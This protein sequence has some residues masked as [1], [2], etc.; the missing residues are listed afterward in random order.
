MG[1]SCEG[2]C[3]AQERLG[4]GDRRQRSWAAIVPSIRSSV[5]VSRVRRLD[6]TLR[7]LCIG[8]VGSLLFQGF[9]IERPGSIKTRNT[10][11]AESERASR[12]NRRL[13]F[14]RGATEQRVF[15]EQLAVFKPEDS[16][17]Q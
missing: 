8:I 9:P 10:I 15:A 7:F 16:K 2:D 17:S 1:R 4:R 5:G 11:L 3:D 14:R 13:T 6:A 12:D